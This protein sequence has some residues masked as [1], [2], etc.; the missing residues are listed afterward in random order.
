MGLKRKLQRDSF[1]LRLV[2]QGVGLKANVLSDRAFAF[3]TI[4]S[5][6]SMRG[7]GGVWWWLVGA[8]WCFEGSLISSGL[9]QPHL[10][11]F[12]GVS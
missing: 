10:Q 1:D 5:A 3:H 11:T 4:S 7:V 6:T 8:W 9:S 2:L 12:E